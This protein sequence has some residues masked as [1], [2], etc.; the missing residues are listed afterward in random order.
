MGCMGATAVPVPVGGQ[1]SRNVRQHSRS[2]ARLQRSRQQLRRTHRHVERIDVRVLAVADESIGVSRHRRRER[3]VQIEYAEERQPVEARQSA[4][5]CEKLALGIERAGRH[6][7]AV[8][9]KPHAIEAPVHGRPR[10]ALELGPEGLE[11]G[12]IERARRHGANFEQRS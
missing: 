5:A 4:D 8:K 11:H 3:R 6:H 2:H 7:R 10:A 9:C 12:V 1:M